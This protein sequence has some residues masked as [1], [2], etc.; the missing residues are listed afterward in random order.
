MPED[1]VPVAPIAASAIA[2]SAAA[3]S[4]PADSTQ[5]GAPAAPE[6]D[7]L[8]SLPESW[9]KEI[10]SLRDEAAA[11]RTSHKPY[12]E[13]FD[14]YSDADVQ[15]LLNLASTI[16]TDTKAGAEMMRQIADA[17]LAEGADTPAPA[18]AETPASGA[19]DKPLTR[20]DIEKMMAE[21]DTSAKLKSAEDAIVAEAKD[22]GYNTGT[23]QYY[24]LL[25]EAK[26]HH[27]GSLADAHTAL[28]A[29]RQSV[30]DTYLAKKKSDAEATPTAGSG[31][32]GPP[33]G[34]KPIKT[35][36][37]ARA[38]FEARVAGEAGQ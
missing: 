9:Q 14:G 35:F 11:G 23:R 3:A 29:E 17:L 34:E 22:L 30:I 18:P 36:A 31:A 6:P 10:R 5:P 13:A 37:D 1:N 24:A 16:K 26:L 2:D 33:S 15:V 7:G 12:K 19:E 8:D 27:K 21:K 32:G 20:A 4:I 38:A 28:E 25:M